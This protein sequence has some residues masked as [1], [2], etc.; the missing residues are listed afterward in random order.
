MPFDG[1]L[2]GLVCAAVFSLLHPKQN[3]I[4]FV[5]HCNVAVIYRRVPIIA[6]LCRALKRFILFAHKPRG[7]LYEFLFE[8]KAKHSLYIE[9]RICVF[10]FGHKVVTQIVE[11]ASAAEKKNP[12][13]VIYR[14]IDFRSRS[15]YKSV[16]YFDVGM[17]ETRANFFNR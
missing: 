15:R 6:I 9:L 2:I 12:Y 17:T 14:P 13:A 16:G 7:R 5:Y 3:Q 10:S 4:A 1:V 8:R 11:I